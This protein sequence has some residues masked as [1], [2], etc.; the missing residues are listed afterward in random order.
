MKFKKAE[1][2]FWVTTTPC[3]PTSMGQSDGRDRWGWVRWDLATLES[4]A[5]LHDSMM[6]SSQTGMLRAGGRE[7]HV[8]SVP[9]SLRPSLAGG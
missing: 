9:S 4:F 7:A 2:Q 3:I 6:R 1:C 8:S 5:N